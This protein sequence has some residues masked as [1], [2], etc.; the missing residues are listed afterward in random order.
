L[1]MENRLAI[2]MLKWGC[3]GADY[4]FSPDGSEYSQR[5]FDRVGVNHHLLRQAPYDETVGFGEDLELEYPKEVPILFVGCLYPNL[6]NYRQIL[7]QVLEKKY[8]D[9]FLWVG[10]NSPGEAREGRLSALFKRTKVVI[11]DCINHPSYWSNRLYE[12]IGRGGFLIHPYTPDI[13]NEFVEDEEC[14]YYDRWNFDQLCSLID[15]YIDDANEDKR[16]AII[17][18]GMDRVKRDYTLLNR[19]AELLEVVNGTRSR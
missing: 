12:T 11:G 9:K 8:G 10:K 13:E 3:W 6:D 7:L 4:M 17:K 2:S 5:L 1:C 19:C 16:Q 14:V 18:R 15:F